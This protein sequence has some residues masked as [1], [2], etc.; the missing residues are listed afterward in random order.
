[1]ECWNKYCIGKR[2]VPL[3]LNW[4]KVKSRKNAEYT[5]HS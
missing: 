1:M 5:V 4:K 2:K 3:L